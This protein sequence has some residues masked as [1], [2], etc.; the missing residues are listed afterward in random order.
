MS[1]KLSVNHEKENTI[2]YNEING[3]L[4]AL[5][6]GSCEHFIEFM[7]IIYMNAA[8]QFKDYQ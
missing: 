4:N 8:I 7:D 3:Y 1:R 6:I 2:D 5:Y